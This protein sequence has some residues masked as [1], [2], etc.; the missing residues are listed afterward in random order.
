MAW[1]D[2]PIT[3]DSP[4]G[5]LDAVGLLLDHNLVTRWVMED[6]SARFGMLETIREYGLDRLDVHGEGEP[7]RRRHLRWFLD[8][9]ERASPELFTAAEA[10]QLRRFDREDGNHRAALAWAFGEKLGPDLEGGLRLAGALGDAWF[11]RGRLAE[12]RKWLEAAVAASAGQSPSA[13]RAR[14]LVGAC[15]FAHEQGDAEP[16]LVYGRDG[17]AMANAIDDAPTIARAYALIGNIRMTRDDLDGAERAHRK[18]FDRF[19]LLGNRP[20]TAL[21]LINLALIAYKR[22]RVG[23]AVALAREALEIAREIGD[24][25]DAALALG[26]LGDAARETGNFAEAEAFYGDQLTIALRRGTR[27]ETANVLSGMGGLAA[28]RGEFERAA[29]FLGAADTLY[30]AI[31]LRLPPPARPRWASTVALVRRSLTPARFV[32]AWATAPSLAIAEIIERSPK[33]QRA[34]GSRDEGTRHEKG[35][36]PEALVELGRIAPF[37]GSAEDDGA[38]PATRPLD[39]VSKQAGGDAPPPRFGERG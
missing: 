5:L 39:P 27:T 10:A 9:A 7:V 1:G 38:A 32:Q 31:G 19:T 18:A 16:A 3:D 20:W 26:V 23:R 21:E 34:L 2:D 35:L 24:D 4:T 25:V 6:G 12:G 29:R 13:G 22:G 8:L 28:D 36:E 11:L 37:A 33:P 14:S 17:L 30:R 15:L